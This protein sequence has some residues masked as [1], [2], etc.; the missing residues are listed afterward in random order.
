MTRPRFRGLSVATLL[1]VLAVAAPAF[2]TDQPASASV[3]PGCAALPAVPMLTGY[4][5][6][7]STGCNGPAVFTIV[8]T[9]QQLLATW[10]GVSAWVTNGGV[11]ACNSNGELLDFGACAPGVWKYRTMT[12]QSGAYGLVGGTLSDEVSIRC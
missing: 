2:A 6:M 5:V 10:N 1:A 3:P 8:Y 9:C 7:S 12:L 11:G 4:G